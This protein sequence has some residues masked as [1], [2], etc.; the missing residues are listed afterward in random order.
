MLLQL[1]KKIKLKSAKLYGCFLK[2]IHYETNDTQTRPTVP[3]KT[4]TVTC[5]HPRGSCSSSSPPRRRVRFEDAADV[6]WA[7]LSSL[8]S[9][10]SLVHSQSVT[11]G[12]SSAPRLDTNASQVSSRLAESQ[13]G[14]EGGGVG[15]GL[16]RR[17][18][19]V[20]RRGRW[21]GGT[22]AHTRNP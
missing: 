5:S 10:L 19:G 21:R 6:F 13:Q 7:A 12:T 14:V 4:T 8:V 22:R 18:E 15:L 20:G 17:R 3:R 1:F 11:S 9:S 16:G 2:L